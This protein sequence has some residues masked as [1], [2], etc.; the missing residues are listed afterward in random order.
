MS[1]TMLCLLRPAQQLLSASVIIA[2]LA[3][4]IYSNRVVSDIHIAYI[5]CSVLFFVH[6]PKNYKHHLFTLTVSM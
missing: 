2:G 1:I 5:Q 3:M 4:V 6:K